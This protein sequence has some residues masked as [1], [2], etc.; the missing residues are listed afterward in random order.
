MEISAQAHVRKRDGLRRRLDDFSR[1]EWPAVAS[2]CLRS[3]RVVSS[4]ASRAR[5]ESLEAVRVAD[6]G[7]AEDGD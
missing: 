6:V 4:F 1:E 5:R 2:S 7:A 3:F